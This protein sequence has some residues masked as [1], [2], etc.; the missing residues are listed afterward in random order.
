[1]NGWTFLPFFVPGNVISLCPTRHPSDKLG[2]KKN[3]RNGKN[4]IVFEFISFS[5]EDPFNHLS[6]VGKKE[7]EMHWHSR[8]VAISDR[9]WHNIEVFLSVPTTNSKVTLNS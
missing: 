6:M 9:T 5:S 7:K 4:G 1:M 3:A 2:L 8:K